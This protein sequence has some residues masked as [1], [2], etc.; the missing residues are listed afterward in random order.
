MTVPL[1]PHRSR[2]SLRSRIAMLT[3]LAVAIAI[4]ITT[5]GVYLLVRNELYNQFDAD[6]MRRTEAVAQAISTA[7]QVA[8]FP[9]ALGTDATIGF[10]RTDN[11][12]LPTRGGAAPPTSRQ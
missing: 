2:M 9:A 5:I 8:Q 4:T 7:D 1:P 10:L 11:V 6:L 12:V 3:A